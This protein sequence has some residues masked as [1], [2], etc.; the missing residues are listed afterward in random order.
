M[1]LQKLMVLITD[2]KERVKK[3]L[4]KPATERSPEELNEVAHLLSVSI[5]YHPFLTNHHIER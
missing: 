2:K 3:I 5:L 4:T 1:H